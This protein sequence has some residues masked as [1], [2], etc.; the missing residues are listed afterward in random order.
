VTRLAG[1]IL[2]GA[3][4]IAQDWEALNA[5]A[6]ALTALVLVIGAVFVVIGTLAGD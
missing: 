5:T 4:A 6:A 3:A 1:F 2:V